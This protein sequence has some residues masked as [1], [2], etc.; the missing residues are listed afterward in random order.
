MPSL[1]L[2]KNY[3]FEMLSGGQKMQSTP[4]LLLLN[5]KIKVGCMCN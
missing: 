5:L 3:C 1:E 4:H 2:L